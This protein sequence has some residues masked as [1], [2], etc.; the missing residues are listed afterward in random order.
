MNANVLYTY[1]AVVA[2]SVVTPSAVD[3]ERVDNAAPL[4]RLLQLPLGIV[5]LPFSRLQKPQQSARTAAATT[6]T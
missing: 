5:H 3:I 2:R 1:D 4:H 6:V